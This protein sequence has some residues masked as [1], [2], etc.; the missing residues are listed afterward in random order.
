VVGLGADGRGGSGSGWFC[1]GAGA[2][3]AG[4]GGSMAIGERKGGLSDEA[5]KRRDWITRRWR[6]P[7]QLGAA[8]DLM[9]GYAM[10]ETKAGTKDKRP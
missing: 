2:C 9:C 10:Q 6:P 7:S 4:F 5:P 3:E 1:S 8:S